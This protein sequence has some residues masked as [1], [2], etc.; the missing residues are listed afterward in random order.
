MTLIPNDTRMTGFDYA[1]MTGIDRRARHAIREASRRGARAI[2]H[3]RL[4]EKHAF[5]MGA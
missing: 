5:L 2:R 3:A 1:D 4:A